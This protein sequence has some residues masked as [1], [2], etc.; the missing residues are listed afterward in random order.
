MNVER[1]SA[2]VKVRETCS[3]QMHMVLHECKAHS[4]DLS[5]MWTTSYECGGKH[6]KPPRTQKVMSQL[7]RR[8][9]RHLISAITTTQKSQNGPSKFIQN[10]IDMDHVCNTKKIDI[11]D[12]IESSKLKS[13][14][15]L[16]WN[17]ISRH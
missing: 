13:E 1:E 11:S 4:T 17:L 15:S 2:N 16:T 8:D 10:L 3:Q 9:L 5:R 12:S 14:I 6:T 7:R